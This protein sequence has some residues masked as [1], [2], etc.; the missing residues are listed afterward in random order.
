MNAEL[1]QALESLRAL[2]KAQRRAA[3]L[4][5]N[6]T[7][8]RAV[9]LVAEQEDEQLFELAR[10]DDLAARVA[11]EAL[12][13]RDGDEGPLLLLAPTVSPQT[14]V[15]LLRAL[16]RRVR[17][18]LVERLLAAA[19]PAFLKAPFED[20]RA[21]VHRRGEVVW[22]GTVPD[23][24]LDLV[25]DLVRRLGDALP[26][27]VGENLARRRAARDAAVAL[28]E[29][30]RVWR[31]LDSE[32]I[33]DE[34]FTRDVDALEAAMTA[35]PPRPVLVVGEPG[36]ERAAGPCSRPAPARS[37]RVRASSGSSKAACR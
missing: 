15:F 16:D 8:Q 17:D 6:E 27:S 7:F 12:A 3:A 18:G 2:P 14:A 30:G 23:E 22:L 9:S 32:A 36:P 29:V 26:A 33:E 34:R 19:G 28:A 11:L 31:S 37:T 35:S 24:R 25:D 21:L 20:L 1:E 10:G 13:Q 4:L 5:V